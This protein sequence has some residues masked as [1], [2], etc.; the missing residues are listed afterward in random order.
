MKG[1]AGARKIQGRKGVGGEAQPACAPPFFVQVIFF[2][3]Q[4]ALS[5]ATTTA[6]APA[7]AAAAPATATTT[8]TI[9]YYR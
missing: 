5:A 2:S 8:T 4:L 6:T 7:A 9:Q 3:E 1:A